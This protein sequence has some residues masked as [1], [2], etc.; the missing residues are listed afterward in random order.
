MYRRQSRRLTAAP[1]V[2]TNTVNPVPEIADQLTDG[3]VSVIAG[4]Y[5]TDDETGEEYFSPSSRGTGFIVSSDG[6]LGDQFSCH[7]RLRGI[8]GGHGGR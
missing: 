1:P 2:I 8:Y 3:V 5:E 7:K 6:Y 4:N